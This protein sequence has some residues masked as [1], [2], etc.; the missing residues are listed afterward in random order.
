MIQPPDM[1]P[2]AHHTNYVFDEFADDYD[3]SFTNSW[4]GKKQRKQVWNFLDR[5]VDPL[6]TKSVLEINCGTG[7][8]ACYL[9]IKGHQVIASDISSSMLSIANA[10]KTKRRIQNLDFIQ[11]DMR[12]VDTGLDD[13]SVDLIFSN[14]GGINCISPEDIRSLS[15]G[16]RRILKKN[17]RIILVVMSRKCLWERVYFKAKGKKQEAIRRRSDK[18]ISAAIGSGS[19]EVWYYSPREIVELFCGEFIAGKIR[20]IGLFIPPSYLEKAIEGKGIVKRTLSVL[21][22]LFENVSILSDYADHYLIEFKKKS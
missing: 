8:D 1:S 6:I 22:K 20:P 18:S 17:G 4:I 19:Q 10:K 7:E 12:S 14:F 15:S 9:S 2:P 21:E 16:F 5:Y 3:K 13:S 11:S